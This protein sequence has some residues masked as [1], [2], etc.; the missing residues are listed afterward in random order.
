MVE[1]SSRQ[2]YSSENKKDCTSSDFDN[3]TLRHP[4]ILI[5]DLKL[6]SWKKTC[7]IVLSASKHEVCIPLFT[8]RAYIEGNFH[9]ILSLTLFYFSISFCLL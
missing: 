5:A 4:F 2:T 9:V 8:F 1:K 6:V 7:I 3:Y